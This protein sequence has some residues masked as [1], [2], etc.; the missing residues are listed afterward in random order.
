MKLSRSRAWLGAGA[1][2][3]VLAL[4][5]GWVLL[6]S[7][8][9]AK[10]STLNSQADQITAANQS[11][12]LQIASL[13]R[14]FAQLPAMRQQLSQY[15]AH[16]PSSAAMSAVL[17]QLSAAA[18][19]SHVT[20]VT[21][22]PSSLSPLNAAT[23]KGLLASSVNINLSGHYAAIEAFLTRLE[24][25]QRSFLVTGLSIS[26]GAASTASQPASGGTATVTT[27]P[28]SLQATITGRI[29]VSTGTGSTG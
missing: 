15:D 6:V 25:L 12:S 14:E 3:A 11:L 27:D 29:F 1:A 21:I 4:V 16:I 23:G 19:A 26:K 9:R 7:P 18:T 5:L 22:S 28:N 17:R 10:A 2:V 8:Q 20:L 13:K 24:G